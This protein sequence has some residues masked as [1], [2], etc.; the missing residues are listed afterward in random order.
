MRFTHC[1]EDRLSL[2]TIAKSTGTAMF[3]QETENKAGLGRETKDSYRLH[4]EEDIVYD[5]FRIQELE[6]LVSDGGFIYY[7]GRHRLSEL[8]DYRKIQGTAMFLTGAKT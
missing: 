1:L 4:L 6:S 8:A 2:P 7:L 5:P 3:L